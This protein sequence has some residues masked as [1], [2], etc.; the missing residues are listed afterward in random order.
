MEEESVYANALN[1]LFF[2]Y[3][4]V[5][6][7]LY[8]QFS[9]FKKAWNQI[10]HEL[11]AA[12]NLPAEA[13]RHILQDHK[14]VNPV[15]L[16]S[17]LAD[18]EIHC[19]SIGSSLYP[20][21]L[22][23]ISDPPLVLYAKGDL[24]CMHQNSI[25]IVGTRKNSAYGERCTKLIS[26]QLAAANLGVV[27]GLAIGIDRIA[28]Q[29][30]IENQVF[31]IAV[32]AHGFNYLQPTQNTHLANQI[33][34]NGGLLISEFP[35]FTPALKQNFLRRNRLISGLSLATVIIECPIKSGAMNTAYHAFDQNR[36]VYTMPGD[37]FNCNSQGPLKLIQENIAYP[38]ENAGQILL[39][40]QISLKNKSG[41][42]LSS[43]LSQDEQDLLGLFVQT[44]MPLEELHAK[45]VDSK[46]LALQLFNLEMKGIVKKTARGYALSQR[47]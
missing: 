44:E 35:F 21:R 23:Q 1:V 28:H 32:L 3:Y 19:V 25:G 11:L 24:A 17:F 27:S 26:D 39:D 40:L 6:K 22:R 16:H 20:S 38:I 14:T 47:Y 5:Q 18:K 41:G 33:T 36:N 7:F 37:V 12:I 13:I 30:A 46:K 4:E 31:T 2:R 10:S 34:K 43:R 8:E 9:S 45:S 29:Q 42:Q 15:G